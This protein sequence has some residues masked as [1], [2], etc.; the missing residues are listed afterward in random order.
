MA[1]RKASTVVKAEERVDSG[2]FSDTTQSSGYICLAKISAPLLT[3]SPAV[4]QQSVDVFA[5]EPR[6]RTPKRAAKGGHWYKFPGLQAC[7]RTRDLADFEGGNEFKE[8]PTLRLGKRNDYDVIARIVDKH[9]PSQ[10]K[11]S[12]AQSHEPTHD[13]FLCDYEEN[14]DYNQNNVP[15]LAKIKALIK[16]Y[17]TVVKNPLIFALLQDVMSLDH[18]LATIQD[19]NATLANDN[20]ALT[21]NNIALQIEN[22]VLQKEYDSMVMGLEDEDGEISVV[23]V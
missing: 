16:R 21:D 4:S 15:P 10:V 20:S 6:L 12:Q 3:P 22:E 13:D 9:V 11:I 1:K 7:P 23:E 14:R 8:S 17:P 19:E 5:D 2:F 18:D